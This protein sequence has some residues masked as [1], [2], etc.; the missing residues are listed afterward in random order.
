MAERPQLRLFPVNCAIYQLVL[1][2]LKRLASS[3]IN[4]M[5]WHR[6][7]VAQP[8]PQRTFLRSWVMAI[9]N[10]KGEGKREE[11]R[12]HLHSCFSCTRLR[13]ELCVTCRKRATLVLFNM[14]M[15]TFES[16]VVSRRLLPCTVCLQW[17][18]ANVHALEIQLQREILPL[19]PD[20]GFLMAALLIFRFFPLRFFH[21]TCLSS[22]SLVP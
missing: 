7:R 11:R 4:Q 9:D 12:C 8:L 18:P 13:N 2:S 20:T 1:I 22:P 5:P 19:S 17:T 21:L 10:E 15:M 14:Q 6:S 16:C 3:W